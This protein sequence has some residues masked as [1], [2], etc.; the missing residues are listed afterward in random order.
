MQKA[1]PVAVI[2]TARTARSA[3]AASSRSIMRLRWSGGDG[4]A[5]LGPVEGDPGDP[6]LDAVADLVFERAI[7][8]HGRSVRTP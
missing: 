5:D 4:V 3:D 1:L 8:G 2:T 7:V 6:V